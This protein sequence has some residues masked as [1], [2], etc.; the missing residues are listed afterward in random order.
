MK[1]ISTAACVVVSLAACTTVNVKPLAAGHSIRHVCIQDNPKV[2]VGDFVGVLRDGLTRHGFTS[3]V[4]TSNAP[5]SCDAVM[6]Y[7]ARRSWDLAPYMTQADL[8]L[9]R[10]GRQIASAEYRLVNNGGLSLNKWAGTQEKLSPVID[11]LL[12]PIEGTPEAINAAA[13]STTPR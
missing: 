1:R 13:G 6:T 2:L 3:E 9:E 10:D 12:K 7:T 4:V 5:A 8:S 11:Q